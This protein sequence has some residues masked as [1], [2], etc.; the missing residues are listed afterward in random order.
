MGFGEAIRS[1]F[2]IYAVVFAGRSRRSEFWW[3]QLFTTLFYVAFIIVLIIVGVLAGGASHAGT[4]QVNVMSTVLGGFAAVIGNIVALAM[5]IPAWA[6]TVR[7]LHDTDHSGWWILLSITIV[8]NILLLVWFCSRGTPG[9]N[10]FG[11]D[12]LGDIA[13]VFGNT[14][15]GY[16]GVGAYR[17]RA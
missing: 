5:F 16:A 1:C 15:A 10:R 13:G 2:G 8:G 3:W 14:P 11:S 17:S 12:P 6:V 9:S 7:R 4:D